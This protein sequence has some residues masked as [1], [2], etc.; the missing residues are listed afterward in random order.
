MFPWLARFWHAL[1]PIYEYTHFTLTNRGKE[2]IQD[3][4]KG[5]IYGFTTKYRKEKNS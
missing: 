5:L 1:A 4:S 3:G 2:G